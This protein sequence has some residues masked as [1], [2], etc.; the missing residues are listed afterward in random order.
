MMFPILL[1][2]GVI[3]HALESWAVMVVIGALHSAEPSV[4]TFSYQGA[5]WLVLLANILVGGA[6]AAGKRA[7]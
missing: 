3:V 6:V 5:L 2:L 7:D 1:L 4:P